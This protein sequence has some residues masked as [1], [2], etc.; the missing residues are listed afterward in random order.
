MEKECSIAVFFVLMHVKASSLCKWY[1][2]HKI[3]RKLLLVD[4]ELVAK[5][6]DVLNSILFLTT[7]FA[8]ECCY[9]YKDNP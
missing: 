3:T 1:F 8:F 2:S 6:I 9:F 5:R 4:I 7:L